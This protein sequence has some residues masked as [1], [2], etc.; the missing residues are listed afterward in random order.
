MPSPI[1]VLLDPISL[2]VFALYAALILWEHFFPARDLPP[3]PAW[4]MRG[5]AAFVLFFALSTYLPLLWTQYL[6][7]WQLFDL[8][9]LG[10][11]P[12]ALVGVLV[13]EGMGY[14]YHRG[15]H[16]SDFLW[17]VLHQMHHSAERVDAWSAFWFH[18]LDMIGWTVV[19]SLA[20]TL[21]VGL[22]AP[23]TTA[24]MLAFTLLAIFQHTNVRT[25]QWL[26][27]FVQR[28]ESHSWH[29]A[30]GQHRHNYADVPLFD[31]LFGTFH[32]PR[33]FAPA[34]GFYD[35]ASSRLGDMLLLREISANPL[36]GAGPT[37]SAPPPGHHSG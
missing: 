37:G 5:L 8:T 26:G 1:D 34:T 20:L 32:N 6:L 21:V 30:R 9:G 28:P 12:G 3:T 10:T 29:H 19:S 33:E 11:A 7:P 4:R 31:I 27:Y 15:M 2:T 22:S 17:R 24:A 14:F 18:P 36:A 25:P 23:A 16:A 35:G 13:Y